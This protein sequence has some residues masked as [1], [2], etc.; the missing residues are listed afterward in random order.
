MRVPRHTS[1]DVTIAA[2]SVAA[3]PWPALTPVHQNSGSLCLERGVR[4]VLRWLRLILLGVLVMAA[5]IC[6]PGQAACFADSAIGLGAGAPA[7]LASRP[8]AKTLAYANVS[9]IS[10]LGYACWI[11]YEGYPVVTEFGFTLPL[12][13]AGVLAIDAGTGLT[14]Y[15]E[16]GRYASNFGQV[17]QRTIP[18]VT[19]GADGRPTS[20]SVTH[21]YSYLSKHFGKR[22]PVRATYYRIANYHLIVQ[23]ALGRMYDK[24]RRAY[25]WNPLDPNDC[26]SFVQEA[27]AYGLKASSCFL[28]GNLGSVAEHALAW[29]A[30]APMPPLNTSDL[31]LAADAADWPAHQATG[32]GNSPAAS[33]VYPAR[34]PPGWRPR[35]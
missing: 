13:H 6:G 4:P 21:L 28:Q 9:P 34:S 16:Y 35:R 7:A 33:M 27:I 25:S 17:E 24:H 3:Q 12:G 31:R 15:F 18:N 10:R 11:E 8:V 5:A 22:R 26:W 29:A 30:I 1:L 2:G 32:I 23:F 19:I 14:K 20:D